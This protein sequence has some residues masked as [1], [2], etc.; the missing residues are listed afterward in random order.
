MGQSSKISSLNTVQARFQTI[1]FCCCCCEYKYMFEN[2]TEHSSYKLPLFAS[3][4]VAD[5]CWYLHNKYLHLPQPL[6]KCSLF[7]YLMI[8]CYYYCYGMILLMTAAVAWVGEGRGARGVGWFFAVV[9]VVVFDNNADADAMQRVTGYLLFA[10]QILR[11]NCLWYCHLAR[12]TYFVKC[13]CLQQDANYV[14]FEF[15]KIR[16]KRNN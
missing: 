15:R 3:A 16:R 2:L 9:M 6:V 8:Y 10:Y 5:L 13:H 4:S 1:I 12:T 7:K 14:T 11:W